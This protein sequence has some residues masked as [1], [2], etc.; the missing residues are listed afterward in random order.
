MTSFKKI[1]FAFAASLLTS[2]LA[3]AQQGSAPPVKLPDIE[4]KAPATEALPE[5][6]RHPA[7]TD[8]IYFNAE[9]LL[10]WMK[11]DKVPPLATTGTTGV[12]GN[13]NTTILFGNDPMGDDMRLGAR[14]VT[15]YWL[16]REH[17]LGVEAN[18]L[19]LG[20]QTN[21]TELVS[22][23]TPLLAQPFQDTVQGAAAAKLLASSSTTPGAFS[24][25]FDS[26]LWG[27]EANFKHNLESSSK[28]SIDALGGFRYLGLK[29][30]LNV[31][32]TIFD[33]LPGPTI[34]ASADQFLTNSDFYGAQIGASVEW[35]HERWLLQATPKLGIGGTHQGV[36]ISGLSTL[37]SGG[38]SSSTPTGFLA[39]DTNIGQYSREVFTFVPELSLNVGYQALDYLRLYAGYNILYWSSVTRPGQ[40]VDLN[41]GQGQ[42][43]FQ[44]NSTELWLQGVN[45]G[46]ELTF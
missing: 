30:S 22:S 7:D 46:L 21:T 31:T 13:P 6:D 19:F 28:W 36:N 20:S 12:L 15:G 44:F 3:L 39:A 4:Q 35:R 11:G 25:T 18:F 1:R 26:K 33:P 34:L 24:A 16:N 27:V 43:T 8:K 45:L 38:A 14:F 5:V 23:G 32:G 40:A 17:T 9:L 41:I 37:T 29:E 42:P 10:W 2:S